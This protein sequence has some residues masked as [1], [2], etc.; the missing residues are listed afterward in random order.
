[1]QVYYTV[2]KS[3]ILWKFQ[4]LCNLLSKAIIISWMQDQIACNDKNN[5]AKR[6]I[7]YIL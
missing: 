4:E 3:Q 5:Y 6:L 7:E 2:Q 1:M